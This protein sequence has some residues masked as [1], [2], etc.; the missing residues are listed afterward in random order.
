MRSGEMLAT[1]TADEIKNDANV[2]KYYLG[3]HFTF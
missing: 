2:R 1:G 3:E